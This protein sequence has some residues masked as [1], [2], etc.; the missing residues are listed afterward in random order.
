MSS[1][2]NSRRIREH[3]KK[4][5]Y[6]VPIEHEWRPMDG[7]MGQKLLLPKE[8][9]EGSGLYHLVNVYK[10]QWKDPPFSMGKLTISC[11]FQ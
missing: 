10:K 11:H 2:A 5:S 1:I 3:Q 7:A 9:K 4:R 6:E 8:T